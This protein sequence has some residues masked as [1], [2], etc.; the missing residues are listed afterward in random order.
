MNI[1]RIVTTCIAAIAAQVLMHQV[2][3]GQDDTAV[4]APSSSYGVW[5]AVEGSEPRENLQVMRLK[6]HPQAAPVPALKYRLIPDP[7]ER[8]D[9]NAAPAYL[10]AMGFVE[11]TNARIALSKLQR[12]WLDEANDGQHAEFGAP[13]DGWREMSPDRLPLDEVKAY[14]HLISF[15]EQLLFDAARRKNYSQDRAM[16]REPN[17]IG[18][19]L[20]EVQQMR[21]L[22]RQQIVRMRYAIAQNRIDDAV[23]ILGQMLAMANHIGQDEFLVSTLVGVAI[24]GM[25]TSEG[26]ALSQQAAT[27]NLYWAIAACPQ[28]MIDISNAIETERILLERQFPILNEVDET[29]RSKE[30]WADFVAR[31]LPQ[32]NEFA[33]Q[34]NSWNQSNRLPD[35]LDAFQ[36]AT[37]V[38]AQYEPA[39]RFLNEACGMSKEQLDKYPATQIT[40]LAVVK[41]HA[42]SM[43]EATTLFY[44]PYS[45]LQKLPRSS[46]RERWR[47]DLGWIAKAFDTLMLTAGNQVYKAIAREKQ[48][49]ALWQTVEA[50]RMTAAANSGQA[51]TSLD[52][53]VVPLPLD[54]VTNKPF[55]YSVKG[56]AVTI[57]G[58]RIN[59][60]R[61]QLAIEVTKPNK[62]KN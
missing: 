39:R 11:Q 7:A 20:P 49:L 33:S 5:E 50:L 13:P 2:A 21:E 43:D 52:E 10:K 57:T 12:K 32:W 17:P 26:L 30:F 42:I 4:K 25:A 45:D 47:A 8:T 37:I 15:Q 35:N 48:R 24:E 14:L 62:E 61:Y 16:E 60:R 1:F 41:Y 31:M 3:F 34:V 22:T 51:P 40:F 19:L 56:Q 58:G 27:P 38:A 53:F 28:P 36:F 23:E 44:Q 6:I 18:Y 9:G 54:P 29:V 46:V 55:E 59:G